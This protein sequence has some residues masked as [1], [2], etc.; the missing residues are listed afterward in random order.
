MSPDAQDMET[1]KRATSSV[2]LISPRQLHP[3][4]ASAGAVAVTAAHRLT[5]KSAIASLHENEVTR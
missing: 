1:A 4:S 5:S 2:P 3:G